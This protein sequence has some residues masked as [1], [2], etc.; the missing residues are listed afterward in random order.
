M[1][2]ITIC[3]AGLTQAQNNFSIKVLDAQQD[4][5][6]TDFIIKLK[7]IKNG[8]V[9]EARTNIEG[10]AVFSMLDGIGKYTAMSAETEKYLM[11]NESIIIN[12]NNQSTTLYLTTQKQLRLDEVIISSHKKTSINRKDATVSSIVTKKEIEAMPIEG[13]DI[14]KSFIRLPNVTLST[15]GYNEAPQISIN[16]GSGI[17]TNYLIDGLDNNERFLGNVKFNTPFGFTES[18]T[19]LTNNYSVEY[20]NTSNGIVNVTTRSGT[21]KFGGEVF[22]VTRPGKIVDSR[23]SFAGVDL[24]GNPVKDGFQRQQLGVGVGGAAIGIDQR[25]A[26]HQRGCPGGIGALAGRAVRRHHRDV[27]GVAAGRLQCSQKLLRC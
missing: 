18:A 21:N 17:Y 4:Q 24:Y 11:L 16:G 12:N 6:V 15:L 13:R 5:P 7:N 10:I 9:T 3:I 22:Y 2:C 26:G 19:I 8:N 1:L 27:R 23:S 14:T 25:L 20:G